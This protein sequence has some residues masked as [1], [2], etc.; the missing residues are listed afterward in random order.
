MLR[1]CSQ[2]LRRYPRALI[3]VLV[4]T[5]A[6]Q[7]PA[8]EIDRENMLKAA[9]VYKLTRY[10][11]WPDDSFEGTKSAL[12]ICV[13]GKTPVANPLQRI[14][15]RDVKGHPV[16]VLAFED[17]IGEARCHV[18]FIAREIE[19]RLLNA[20]AEFEQRPIL[21]V[22]EIN[23]FAERGGV[24]AITQRGSR[25]GFRINIDSAR[26]AKLTINAPLLE[27]AEI[28]GRGRAAE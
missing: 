23:A 12:N 11:D 1:R 21:S 17:E 27:I 24:I 15:R 14:E 6:H 13:L 10:V 26:R 18:V 5:V 25:F 22:S 20:L 4:I 7:A 8:A 16:R 28:V 9:I 3:A 19:D 2:I